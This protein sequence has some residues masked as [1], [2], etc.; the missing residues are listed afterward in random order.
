M[1]AQLQIQRTFQGNL[2]WHQQLP[3]IAGNTSAAFLTSLLKAS[4]SLSNHFFKVPLSFDGGPPAP[5]LPPPKTTVMARTIVEMVIER[6][7]SIE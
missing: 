5:S 6:A 7:V 4:A 2:K 1:Y 3:T